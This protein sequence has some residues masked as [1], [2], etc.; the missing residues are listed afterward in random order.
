MKDPILQAYHLTFAA[1][2]LY[3]LTFDLFHYSNTVNF[4]SLFTIQTNI[5][6]I[7]LFF[8][9]G[10]YGL[11]ASLRFNS[12]RGAIT[13]Y[14]LV[15]GV[16][17]AILLAP[18]EGT[19][20][21]PW[22]SFELHKIMPIAVLLSWVIFPPLATIPKREAIKWLIYPFIYI[23]YTLIHGQIADWYP[24]QFLNPHNGGIEHV[25][26]YIIVISLASEVVALGIIQLGNWRKDLSP[27]R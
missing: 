27:T 16:V 18:T 7:I 17:Y 22:V 1:L 26:I 15:T 5:F 10:I 2:T 8:F 14:M 11:D 23:F 19:L 13:V 25:L 21:Y 9:I 20:A 12:I 6:A 3:T 4:F 24:Y